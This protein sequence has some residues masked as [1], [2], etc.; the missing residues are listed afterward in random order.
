MK[1]ALEGIKVVDLTSALNGPF[2]TMMM[3]D[4]GAEVLKIEPVFG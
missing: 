2:C 3:A 4:Y 1:K